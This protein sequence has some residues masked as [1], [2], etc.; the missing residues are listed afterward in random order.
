M[1][2]VRRRRR[3]KKL[4]NLPLYDQGWAVRGVQGEP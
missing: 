2:A 4:T 1:M 3:A